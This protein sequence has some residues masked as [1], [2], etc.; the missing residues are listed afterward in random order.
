VSLQSWGHQLFVDSAD[1]PRVDQ[2]VTDLRLNSSTT[3]EF[4]ASCADPDFKTNP[5]A[6]DAATGSTPTT[7]ASPKPSANPSATGSAPTSTAP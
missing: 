5:R 1:D 4:G 3:P 7:T 6:P 2:F